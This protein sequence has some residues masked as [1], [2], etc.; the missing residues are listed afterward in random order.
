[1]K[2]SCISDTHLGRIRFRKMG[3]KLNRIEEITYKNWFDSID[4]IIKAN[5]DVVIIPGDIFDNPN[6]SSIAI[7]NAIVG[8][9]KL[10]EIGCPVLVIAGNHDYS[11]KNQNSGTHPFDILNSIGFKNIKFVWEDYDIVE[12]DGYSIVL[13]PHQKIETKKN[14]LNIKENNLD[15]LMGKI[16]NQ[17]RNAD[18]DK[19]ILVTHG[20]LTSWSDLFTQNHTTESSYIASN[21]INDKFANDYRLILTGHIHNSMKQNNRVPSGM[22]TKISVGS[23]LEDNDVQDQCGVLNLDISDTGEIT[24]SYDCINVPKRISI[25]FDNKDALN[26]YLANVEENIYNISYAG[27]WNDIDNDIYK[28]AINKAIV[29]NIKILERDDV[30]ISDEMDEF[31]KW[32]KNNYPQKLDEFKHAVENV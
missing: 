22:C 23:I 4:K 6:P 25:Y 24:T 20:V 1:M 7:N 32:I 12:V 10:N 29:M 27:N 21:I 30:Q 9:S 8:F 2:I 14:N 3:E 17:I 18:F 19:R 26:E 11:L 28:Q 15:I 31:W 5:P 16:F 13:L